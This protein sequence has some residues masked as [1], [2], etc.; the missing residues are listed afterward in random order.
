MAHEPRDPLDGEAEA[1]KMRETREGLLETHVTGTLVTTPGVQ[2]P[3]IKV[4]AHGDT[5]HLSGVVTDKGQAKKAQE[6]AESVD[7]VERVVSHI[8]VSGTAGH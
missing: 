6:I 4:T 8:I 1:K 7:G 2:T 3:D 5:V